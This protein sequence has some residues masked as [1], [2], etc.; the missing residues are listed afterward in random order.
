MLFVFTEAFSA[1]PVNIGT[2]REMR[3]IAAWG[4]RPAANCYCHKQL[5]LLLCSEEREFT[6]MFLSPLCDRRTGKQINMLHVNLAP[7]E[8]G[9]SSNAAA[10][11][12]R[13]FASNAKLIEILRAK[14][15]ASYF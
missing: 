3:P 9:I 1:K 5:L 12:H 4:H 11:W 15:R 2:H 8:A 10:L 6:K 13:T 7:S 14:A